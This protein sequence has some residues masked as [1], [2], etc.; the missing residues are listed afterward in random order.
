MHMHMDM[1]AHA[2]AFPCTSTFNMCMQMHMQALKSSGLLVEV[3]KFSKFLHGMALLY[4]TR[5]AHTPHWFVPR[6]LHLPAPSHPAAA[7]APA[8]TATATG[9]GIGDTGGAAS[10]GKVRATAGAVLGRLLHGPSRLGR[11]SAAPGAGK[12]VVGSGVS[13][14]RAMGPATLEEM[15]D[16]TDPYAQVRGGEGGPNA[17]VRG[18][19]GRGGWSIVQ[20]R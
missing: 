15:A 2:D 7:P 4:P 13:V 16:T 6:T 20:A 8:A 12:A 5:L 1:H 11:Q 10:A 17:Q 3:P 14:V 9:T 19:E 18:G